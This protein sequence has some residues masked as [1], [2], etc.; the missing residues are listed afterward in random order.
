MTYGW[1]TSK[2]TDGTFTWKVTVSGY[3]VATVVLQSGTCSTRA[4]AEGRAKKWALYYRSQ[5]AKLAA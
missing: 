1:N 4:K 3:Q 5:A 2:Q